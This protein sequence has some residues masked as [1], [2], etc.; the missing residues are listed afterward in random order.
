MRASGRKQLEDRVAQEG[1]SPRLMRAF[2][3][4]DR[5]DF[6]PDDE[7]DRAYTDRPVPLPAGQTTSQPSLI[8]KM[9]DV[10]AVEPDDV[11]LEVGAGFGFQTA[12]LARLAARVVAI[13]R[14]ES[15]A[16]RARA[17]LERVGISNAEVVV[18]DG[19]EGWPPEA[20]YDAIVVSAAADGIPEALVDQLAESG[21]LV[22]PVVQ[23]GGE[24]VVRFVKRDEEL[25]DAQLIT[26]ARF[27][28]LL[29]GM[30]R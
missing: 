25:S 30:P 26:P 7:R 18:G 8:A 2:E 1:I 22:I 14:Y 4:L 13:E 9:V 20:P 24:D 17:N 15:L 3:S 21:R 11:V 28:P 16:E 10:A 19:W 23:G 12:L 5:A 27:V 6:V 29:R